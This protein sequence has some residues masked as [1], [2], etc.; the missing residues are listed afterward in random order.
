MRG[1]NRELVHEYF[2]EFCGDV[3]FDADDYYHR[4]QQLKDTVMPATDL[5]RSIRQM[6]TIQE[7]RVCIDMAKFTAG[8]LGNGYEVIGAPLACGNFD[9]LVPQF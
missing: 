1:V 8:F 5:N 7:L 4:C 3:K 6:R 2:L 9:G